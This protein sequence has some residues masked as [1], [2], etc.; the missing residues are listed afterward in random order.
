M[1]L[2][3][4]TT[5]CHA[6]LQFPVKT[7]RTKSTISLKIL[8]IFPITDVTVSK[9]P[10][11]TPPK[12]PDN[13]CICLIRLFLINSI[14]GFST[15]IRGVTP[16]DI[17]FTIGSSKLVNNSRIGSRTLIAASKIGSNADANSNNGGSSAFTISAS[18]GTRV[19]K[20]SATIGKT[21]DAKSAKRGST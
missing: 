20:N 15:L 11:N 8:V 7:F 14:N 12:T 21:S 1:L 19:L 18:G 6:A 3:M 5:F 10:S 9:I 13:I 16:F 17:K 2:K 4:S